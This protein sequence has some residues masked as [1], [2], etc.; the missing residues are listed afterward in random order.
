MITKRNGVG[1]S[2]TKIALGMLAI[3]FC[4]QQASAGS[5]T[6]KGANPNG[7][8]FIELA[9]QIVEVEGSVSTLQDQVDS[10]VDRVDSIEARVGANE[11]AILALQTTNV[12]LEGQ[13][14][15]NAADVVSLQGQVLVLEQDNADL[16]LQINNLGDADGNLQVAIDSNST[17][18]TTLNQS[19][20]ELGV[21]LQDQIDNN[22]DLIGVMQAE[23]G[24]INASLAMKQMIVS[25]SCLPDQ[26][27]Q[28]IQADGSVVCAANNGGGSTAVT[29]LRVYNYNYCYGS[30]YCYAEA[31]CPAGSALTGGAAYGYGGV[32]QSYPYIWESDY[33]AYVNTNYPVEGYGRMWQASISDSYYQS[34]YVYAIALCL[35]F[36]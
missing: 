21:S 26:S 3:A 7:K 5:N 31:V 17:L 15:A 12:L 22:L 8:P 30:N 2:I 11:D 18:I 34:N 28:Q 29:E 14:T 33:L 32:L 35:Q 24:Q 19:I 25:G 6:N 23:I 4:S 36:N 1:K 13:I 27:I 10:L 20:Q 9:G 16:Q